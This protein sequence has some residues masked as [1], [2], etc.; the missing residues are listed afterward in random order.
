MSKRSIS[1]VVL[2]LIGVVIGMAIGPLNMGASFAQGTCR[3]FPETGKQVC[4]RFLITGLTTGVWPS[5]GYR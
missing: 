1:S 4:G 3:T 5:R 2:L